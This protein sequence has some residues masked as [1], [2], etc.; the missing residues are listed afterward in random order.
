[1]PYVSNDLRVALDPL[2]EELA[3]AIK[4]ETG[5]DAHG[6]A[7]AL[8]YAVTQLA[9]ALM[10]EVRYWS[11]ELVA[12]VIKGAAREFERRA[13]APYEDVQIAVNGDVDFY[14]RCRAREVT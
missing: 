12:A 5:G 13:I 8:N 1:M 11:L 2:V 4:R 7:G 14:A 10:P 6:W 3:T 9:T